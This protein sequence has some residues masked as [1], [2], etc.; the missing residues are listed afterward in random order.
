M[1]ILCPSAVVNVWPGEFEKHAPGKFHVVPLG[2]N[3]GTVAKKAEVVKKQLELAKARNQM[4]VVVINHESAW[5]EDFEK[6][7]LKAGFDCVITDESHK[8]KSS[9]GKASLF[10]KKIGA[11]V[12]YRMCLTGTPMP[13][14]PLD[15]FA[16]Y[17][18]LDPG[19]FGTSY[20]LFKQK[21]GKWGGFENRKFLGMREELFE[22][23]NRK[24]H[25]I[26]FHVPQEV[27]DKKLPPFVHVE[28]H[29]ELGKDAARVYKELEKDMIAGVNDGTVTVANALTK[30]L[31]HQQLTGGFVID[32][33]KNVQ[34]IDT[35]KRDLLEDVLEDIGYSKPNKDEETERKPVEPVV[36][37]CKFQSDLD[38]VREI[39]ESFGRVYAELS[40]R[41]N[42]L[43]DTSKM[44]EWCDVLGVQIQAGGAGVDL[45]RARY[46]VY[47]SVGFS[48][49]DYEQ[50]LKRTHRP[51]QTRPVTYIH[52]IA[53]GTVDEKV[54]KALSERKQ[55]VEHVLEELKK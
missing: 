30:L 32:D 16:Q 41:Q 5:R 35:A 31:R 24:M 7:A 54:Y 51:G 14:S 49:G 26:M 52:L 29:C 13:H 8:I 22:E 2:K 17:R 36:V 18:F 11:K 48:L 42:D 21:Y 45:T 46:S 15:I 55:I 53:Q 1:L 38:T 9:S 19:I 50:S 23:F 28:R 43:T 27:L 44:P 6:F 25:S 40:G 4:V 47:Y 20:T 39:T 12:P 33:E 37:F 3:V 10:C 34:A